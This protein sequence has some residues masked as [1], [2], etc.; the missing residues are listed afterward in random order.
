MEVLMSIWVDLGLAV[1]FVA[2]GFAIIFSD[3][4]Q[5]FRNPILRRGRFL[6]ALLVAYFLGFSSWT[7]HVIHNHHLTI[8]VGLIA[9]GVLQA[10]AITYKFYHLKHSLKEG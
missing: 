7:L 3:W 2:L 8:A 5:Y 1:V 6:P 10:L 9:I 4:K